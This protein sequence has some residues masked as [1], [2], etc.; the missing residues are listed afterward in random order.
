MVLARWRGKRRVS[1]SSRTQ[2]KHPWVGNELGTSTQ[3]KKDPAGWSRQRGNNVNRV[4]MVPTCKAISA[5]LTSIVFTFRTMLEHW[6][7]L[8][9]TMT[10]KMCLFKRS[11]WQPFK[12]EVEWG[13]Q[14]EIWAT[15]G[16]CEWTIQLKNTVVPLTIV[17]DGMEKYRLNHEYLGVKLTVLDYRWDKNGD[18]RRELTGIAEWWQDHKLT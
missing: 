8:S 14:K 12:I 3:L 16:I 13:R 7:G 18:R 9:Y 15:W 4:D 1:G 11:F 6:R 17:T 10:P 2:M 5:M